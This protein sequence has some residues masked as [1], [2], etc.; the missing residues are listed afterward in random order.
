MSFF[1]K[2]E[3]HAIVVLYH[4]KDSGLVAWDAAEVVERA[5]ARHYGENI[6]VSCIKVDEDKLKE[7]TL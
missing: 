7:A 6:V 3:T 5:L 4:G 2:E 1:K